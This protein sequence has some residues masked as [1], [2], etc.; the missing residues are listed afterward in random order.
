MNEGHPLF[1]IVGLLIQV[2]AAHPNQSH[3]E[4]TCETTEATEA[5]KSPSHQMKIMKLKALKFQ[6]LFAVRFE[7]K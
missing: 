1:D 2:A 4:R 3:M 6:E 7:S 5:R